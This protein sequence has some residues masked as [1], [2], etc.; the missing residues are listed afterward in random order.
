MSLKPHS[1]LCHVDDNHKLGV[2]KWL[3]ERKKEKKKKDDWLR[4]KREEVK[5]EKERECSAA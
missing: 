3:V 2:G 5:E 1:L 4:E